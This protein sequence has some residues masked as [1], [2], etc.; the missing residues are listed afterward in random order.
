MYEL[1]Y[2]NL[3]KQ[4]NREKLAYNTIVE[5]VF[6]VLWLPHSVKKRGEKIYKWTSIFD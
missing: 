5:V 4:A 3:G 2:Y 6:L 1:K